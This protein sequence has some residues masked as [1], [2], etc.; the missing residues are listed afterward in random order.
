M[1]G[2]TKD[3]AMPEA[4]EASDQI[5]D[6]LDV[7][8]RLSAASSVGHAIRLANEGIELRDSGAYD[9]AATI[10]RNVI[11]LYPH[12]V[13]GWQELG[14]LMALRG[15]ATEALQLFTRAATTDP[16][17]F[18]CCK[19]LVLHQIALGQLDDARHSLFLH[20]PS[21]PANQT[22]VEVYRDFVDFIEEY[23][24]QRALDMI[25]RYETAGCYLSPSQIQRPI[26]AAIESRAPFSLIRLGDGEGAWLSISPED[27]QKFERI[28]AFNRKKTL[29]VWFGTDRFQT[30]PSFIAAS[31][32][33]AQ[34]VQSADLV[35]LPYGL[36][37]AR[38]YQVGSL[39]GVPSCVNILRWLEQRDPSGTGRAYC[40]QDVHLI[41][42]RE[43]FFVRL[44]SLPIEIGI[45]SCHPDI[46]YRIAKAFGTKVCQI[47]IIPEEAGFSEVDQTLS[48]IKGTSG[49]TEP[50]FPITYNRVLTKIRENPFEVRV[51]LVAAGFL[52]KIY[53]A[54]ARDAGAVALDIGS[55]IDGWAGKVTRPYLENIQDFSL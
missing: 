27:T 22:L 1:T 15:Q 32:R 50:H 5:D 7:E 52:G 12:F 19:H 6:G 44:F 55:I 37:I 36:R 43:G 42:H 10:F 11:E 53:C 13:Y 14:V 26:F 38:E 4:S 30:L 28:Y 3:T 8:A 34:A 23:P 54:A 35:G 20:Q 17:D 49:M 25:S 29:R 41:L 31:R 48:T 47:L 18:Q 45:I 16:S 40:S 9:Q 39:N 33:L 24:K 2:S 51:W 46:G 21:T